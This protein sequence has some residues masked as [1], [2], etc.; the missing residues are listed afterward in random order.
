MTIQWQPATVDA[1]NHFAATT[2]LASGTN[3][4]TIAATDGSGNQEVNVY[5]VDANSAGATFTYDA[6][7][8]LTSE[9]TRSFE[10]DAE[11]R[12]VAV[13]HWDAPQ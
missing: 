12:L 6:N 13:K 8:N 4:V 11:N 1:S 10:W 5:Q 2:S 7:G 9:G 3:T